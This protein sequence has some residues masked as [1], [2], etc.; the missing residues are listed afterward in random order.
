MVVGEELAYA[1]SIQLNAR[2]RYEWPVLESQTAYVQGQ[3][4]Y[5]GESRSDIIEINSA[6]V[7]SYTTFGVRTGLVSDRYSVELYV[8]N[9]TNQNFE[10]ANN[11]INDRERVTV[12]RPRTWGVRVGVTY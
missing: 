3:M 8:D 2:A 7:D 6:D 11:F 5:S 12:G 9:L 10:L 4:V 1:P